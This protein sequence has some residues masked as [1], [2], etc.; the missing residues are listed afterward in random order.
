MRAC[1]ERD[2]N[3]RPCPNR[4]SKTRCARHQQERDRRRN[5]SPQRDIYRGGWQQ[6]SK[7]IRAEQPWCSVCGATE[8][9]SVDHG[10]GGTVL[11][12]TCH[13]ALEARRRGK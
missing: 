10:S 6:E 12:L 11:C 3:G 1:I 9:L 8:R 7:R 4:S 13:G 5:A 2:E